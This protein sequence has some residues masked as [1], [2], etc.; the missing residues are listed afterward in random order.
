M[1]APFLRLAR[2]RNPRLLWRRARYVVGALAC[3]GALAFALLAL[4]WHAFPFPQERLGK[5]TTSPTVLDAKGRPMLTVVA[6]DGEWRYP[7]P[8]ERIS[9]W[10]IKA[11][12]A[13]EDSRF[14]DHAGV[15]ALAVARAAVQNIL[16]RGIVSGASTL[17]MQLCR[18]MDNRPRTFRAKVVESFRALQLDRLLSKDEILAHYLN[19]APYGGN[20]RGAEAASLAY[21]G[22]HAAD[23][24]LDEAALLAGL[25]QSP[26]R[27][28]PDRRLPRALRRRSVVLRRMV[29]EGMISDHAR[30]QIEVA[31]MEIRRRPAPRNAVHAAWLALRMRPAA[32]RTTIDLDVQ[33][34]VER[35]VAERRRHLPEESQLAAVV[36]DI[37]RSA[38]VALVG[39]ADP[40]DPVDGQVNGVLALRS[41]GSAL[42]PFIYAAAFADGR[43][44]PDS[45]VHDLP[46]QRGGWTPANFDRTFLGEV[47]AAD[48]LRRSLNVP[49]ILVAEGVGL[50]R[51]CGTLE[52]VGVRLPPD[53]Q[54]RGGLAL[55]VGGIEVTLLDLT[56]AYATL[57][58]N[59]V[60]KRARLFPD[61]SADAV[62]VL[63]PNICAAVNDILSSHRRR[64]AGVQDV[65]AEDAP[66]FMWK[67][68]TSA[69]RRD[70]WAVGHN[71]RYAIGVWVGRF[72]GTGRIAF[73][74]A[75]SA[76]PLL[77]GLFDL[78]VLRTF[79]PPPPPEPIVVRRPLPPPPEVASSLR[80]TAPE[81]NATFAALSGAAIIRPG[82]NRLHDVSWFLNGRLIGG[83]SPPRLVLPPGQ[84]E[85]RCVGPKGQA[86]NTRFTVCS[87]DL[88]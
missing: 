17:D 85:L 59:G 23:L 13:V 49:A 8:L 9:P 32:G 54:A 75:H 48:A 60:R 76:E 30:H 18:M 37:R 58:R 63:D 80:I 47:T 27:Y 66:W 24:S 53:A 46:L 77:A 55:A 44:A 65:L 6:S 69:G 50:S 15:D 78:P 7:V 12:I 45:L 38:I 4:L 79:N 51:C 57:G 39:S 74:G 10:I 62:R 43:L 40:D 71:R 82:A 72:S 3:L 73:V 22:K 31:P 28:R 52:A 83:D 14:Y 88:R 5:W 56:N 20:L 1:F 70:A 41:P 67:T 33:N 2:T 84:Y 34:E 21:F 25:P 64:P 26:S 87:A 68:G 36:I 35:L 16:A 81:D 19:A 86:S 42:K 61:E 11:T 29:K